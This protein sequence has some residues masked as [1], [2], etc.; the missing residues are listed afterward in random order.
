AELARA[1]IPAEVAAAY[2]ATGLRF[3]ADY[4][5]PRP[6]DPRLLAEI[7]PAVAKAAIDSGV[8][9]RSIPDFDAYRDGL[10]RLVYQT[11]S[12]M[13]PVFAKARR[14]PKRVLFAEGEDE[15]VLRAAQIVVA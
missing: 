3:G 7:A 15:R 1:E 4:L 13:R 14:N 12:V 8:A 10:R 9:T 6:F 2:G 11:G 5:I